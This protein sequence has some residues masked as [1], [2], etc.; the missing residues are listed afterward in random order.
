ME[1]FKAGF[2]S[3]TL[4]VEFQLLE[5]CFEMQNDKIAAPWLE[6]NDCEGSQKKFCLV[7]WTLCKSEK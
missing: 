5:K 2:K 7:M 4:T 6:I 1:I 3:R